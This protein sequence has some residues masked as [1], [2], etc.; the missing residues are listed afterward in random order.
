MV[1]FFLILKTF[2]APNREKCLEEARACRLKAVSTSE[3][4][5]QARIIELIRSRR[6]FSAQLVNHTPLSIDF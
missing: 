3:T 6:Q 2:L 5:L 4:E 1:L